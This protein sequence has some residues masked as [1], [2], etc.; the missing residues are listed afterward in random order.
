VGVPFMNTPEAPSFKPAAAAAEFSYYKSVRCQPVGSKR[1]AGVESEPAEPQ[2]RRP[3]NRERKVMRRI[4]FI[5][6]A[7]R[8][9]IIS[10]VTS[11][12][13]PALI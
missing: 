12:A 11:A 13:M 7:F 3:D 6:I 9:P 8:L 1:A 10:A 4:R 5:L 2:H